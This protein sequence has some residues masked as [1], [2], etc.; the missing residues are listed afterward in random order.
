MKYINNKHYIWNKKYRS[1]IQ[2]V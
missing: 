1:R 2:K